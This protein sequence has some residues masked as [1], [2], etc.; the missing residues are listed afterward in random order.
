MKANLEIKGYLESE[1]IS[2]A[3]LSRK[4]GITS[5]KLNLASILG[6]SIVNRQGRVDFQKCVG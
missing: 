4:T 5:S 6:N 3:F 1:G 2:Q